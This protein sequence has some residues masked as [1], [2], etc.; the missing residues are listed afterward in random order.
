MSSIWIKLT[1]VIVAGT[2]GLLSFQSWSTASTCM[3]RAREILAAADPLDKSPP[4]RVMAAMHKRI[5]ME[6]VVH[7][8]ATLLL[9]RY[10]C[11]GGGKLIAAD[12]LVDHSVVRFALRQ[13]FQ[14]PELVGMMAA[15]ADM[16]GG[17][18][19][20]NR[21]ALKLYRKRTSELDEPA[22]DCLIRKALGQKTFE[23]RKPTLDQ[24]YGQIV[25]QCPTKGSPPPAT[26]VN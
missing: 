22:I 21:G 24:P 11:K 5:S 9:N 14:G 13:T 10:Q 19:G 15:T 17:T 23:F 20:L 4:A 16:G 12:W 18:F 1:I 3:Q 6:N 25:W 26:I 7:M 8:L 2:L